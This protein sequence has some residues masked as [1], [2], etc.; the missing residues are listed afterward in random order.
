MCNDCWRRGSKEVNV[1]RFQYPQVATQV[2]N[3][4]L[5][6]YLYKYYALTAGADVVFSYHKK[7]LC[8]VAR[9]SIIPPKSNFRQSDQRRFGRNRTDK[10]VFRSNESEEKKTKFT[11]RFSRKTNL[12]PFIF[13]KKSMGDSVPPPLFRSFHLRENIWGIRGCEK[14]F[15]GK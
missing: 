11:S 12:S 6:K 14:T 8:L 15:G 9:K 4:D 5:K 1:E 10:L 3:K 13:F 2:E 7:F